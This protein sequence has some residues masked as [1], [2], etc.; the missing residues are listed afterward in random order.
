M[1]FAGIDWSNHALDYELRTAE[2]QVL[3]SGQ[4]QNSAAGLS[5]LFV[6]L[7][8]HAAPGDIGIAFEATNVAWVL[9]LSDRGYLLYSVNPA[10]VVNF[11]KT[12][13]IAG[14]KSDRIDRSLLARMLVVLHTQLK[15]L[16]PDAP[17]IVALRMA[18]EDRVRLVEERTAKLNELHAILK[19]FY[20]AFEGLFGD[21]SSR[22]ALEFLHEFP[23]QAQMRAL[24]PRRLA[25]WLRRHHYPNMNR[26]EAMQA[27]LTAPLLQVGEHLQKAKQ[28]HI[29][30]LASSLLGLCTEIDQRE[31]HI[32]DMFDGLAEAEMYR[33]LPGAGKI[34]APALLACFGRDPERFESVESAR[35]LLGTAPVTRQSGRTCVVTFRRACWKFGRRTLQLLASTS[36]AACEWAQAFYLKQRAS[37]RKHHQALRALAHKWVKIILAMRRTGRPYDQ[38]VFLNSRTRFAVKAAAA[39]RP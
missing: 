24:T 38:A 17:E 18:C 36:C 32:N 15:P 21:L 33:S 1:L 39:V 34:L 30:Y 27:L 11:R 25:N 5:E 8:A 20:P 14:D 9:A 28:V 16:R 31:R 6:K 23:T 29:Q 26:L 7:E 4:V 22:I 10:M 13:A 12:L 2:G 19:A 37:G 35:A 3:A